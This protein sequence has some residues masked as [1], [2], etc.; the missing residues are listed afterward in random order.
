MKKLLKIS[1]VLFIT[2]TSLQCKRNKVETSTKKETRIPIEFLKTTLTANNT[3]YK[4]TILKDEIKGIDVEHIAITNEKLDTFNEDYKA[5]F[6]FIKGNGNVVAADSVYEIVP[7]TILLPQSLKKISINAAKNDTLHYLRITTKLTA[8]DRLDLANFLDERTQNVYY[9]KFIDCESYTEPIKSPNTVSRTILP[10]KYIP[11]I[12][13]GTVQT[14][15][16]DRVGFHEHPM[17]EQL[18]LGLKDNQT[19]TY[20][21]DAQIDFP[22]FSVLHIPLGSSHS[23]SVDENK[24]MYYVW[25]DFFRDAKGEEW[26]KTHN[27]DD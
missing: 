9:A 4:K 24:I 10:N 2:F 3:S 17:L 26:L 14:K 23:V 27:T 25:M 15:G 6:L 8:Q 19:I 22:E 5:I 21:D 13:M 1:F 16:P 18:F 11:R 12:A 20:A 7:E